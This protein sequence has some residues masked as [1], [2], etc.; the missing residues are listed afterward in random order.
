MPSAAESQCLN[1]WTTREVP[2]LII[3]MEKKIGIEHAIVD[4]V[5]LPTCSPQ[6]SKL[7]QGLKLRGPLRTRLIPPSLY[8]DGLLFILTS[9]HFIVISLKT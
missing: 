8:G 9:S 2:A 3:F 6:T 7:T 5:H 1:H 4:Q